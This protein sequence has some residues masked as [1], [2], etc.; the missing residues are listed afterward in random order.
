MGVIPIIAQL[1]CEQII[2][3][4]L[5]SEAGIILHL[6]VTF[7]LSCTTAEIKANF[8]LRTGEA[9]KLIDHEAIG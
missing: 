2:Y 3:M 4:Y 5:H 9:E 7:M 8:V 1:T 6:H